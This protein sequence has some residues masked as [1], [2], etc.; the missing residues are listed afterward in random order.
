MALQPG[1]R[2]RWETTDDNGLPAVRYGFVGALLGE[3]AKV[4]LDGR[5]KGDTEV[6]CQNLKVVSISNIELRLPG[7]D[8]LDDPEL[9]GG[10]VCLWQAEADDAGLELDAV[11]TLEA[12][13]AN[14]ACGGF[15]LARVSA[16]GKSYLLRACTWGNDVVV[17][18][19][20]QQ[21]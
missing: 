7:V 14:K 1:D 6:D 19:I 17:S 3:N 11:E 4:M 21:G 5:L 15:A 20:L 9:R 10:L 18:P 12:D 2:I 8:I 13:I 16:A